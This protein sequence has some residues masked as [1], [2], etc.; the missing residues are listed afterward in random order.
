[1]VAEIANLR[2]QQL[3]AITNATFTGWMGEQEAA[4][5]NRS[6]HSSSLIA[7]LEAIDGPAESGA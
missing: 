1:L 3:K 4:H 2:R 6:T 5:R 7:E